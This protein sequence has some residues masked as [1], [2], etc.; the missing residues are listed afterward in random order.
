MARTAPSPST[1]WRWRLQCW[2]ARHG[3][4]RTEGALATYTGPLGIVCYPDGHRSVA[5]P[6]GNAFDYASF[7]A[8]SRVVPPDTFRDPRHER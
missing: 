5:L 1:R 6:L 3:F 7:A 8:G 4:F 2:L